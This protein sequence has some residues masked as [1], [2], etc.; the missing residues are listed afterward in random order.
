MKK[1]YNMRTHHSRDE[2]HCSLHCED[3]GG[4]GGRDARGPGLLVG[5]L[6]RGTPNG[7]LKEW[8]ETKL[9]PMRKQFPC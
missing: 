8:E 6:W 2:L 3:A 9:M 1:D 4:E 7:E 5:V